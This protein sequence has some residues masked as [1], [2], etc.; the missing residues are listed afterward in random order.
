MT[1]V[2]LVLAVFAFVAL[3]VYG[4]WHGWQRRQRKQAGLPA[5]PAKPERSI[6]G[7]MN[8][9]APRI[10]CCWVIDSAEMNRPSPTTAA[11]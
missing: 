11:R 5:F 6:A 1:R 2:L 4:M 7:T 3:C 10:A 8:R 9:K